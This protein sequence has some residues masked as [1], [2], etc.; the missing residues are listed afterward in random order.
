MKNQCILSNCEYDSED[1]G[2]ANASANVNDEDMVSCLHSLS[3]FWDR[4]MHRPIFINVAEEIPQPKLA[5]IKII[6]QNNTQQMTL[7][8]TEHRTL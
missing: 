8:K 7:L 3:K 2:T 5:L 1:Q 6:L 4:N